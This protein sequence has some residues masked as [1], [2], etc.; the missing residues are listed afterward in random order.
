[1]RIPCAGAL[2]A[3][4]LHLISPGTAMAQRPA[5]SG[6]LSAPPVLRHSPLFGLG[7][8]TIYRGGWGIEIEGEWERAQG[9]VE[10]QRALHAD[11][12]YGVTEDLNVTLTLPLVQ[13]TQ[14]GVLSPG[15]AQVDRDVTGLG[16]VLVRGKYRFWQD[17]FPSGNHQATLF[18]AVKVPTAP[19][20]TEPPLGSGSVDFLTGA[21]VSRETHRYYAWASALARINT[22]GAAAVRR[23][24]EAR[25][26][27]ALGVRPY[28]P[29]W[30]DPDL[31]FLLEFVGVTAARSVTPAGYNPNSGGTVL[32][33]APGMWLTYRNWALK[34]GINLPFH[35]RLNGM[36]PGLDLQ[37][38][39]ALE[40]HFG[41]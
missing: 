13:K 25:W 39:F 12:H 24:H 32:A 2:V 28:V 34:A 3:A 4:G 27:L 41:G 14:G 8:Q 22:T 15:L 33:L 30:T 36:Q 35:Q 9:G 11:L 23:G 16:D 38:V 18:G 7:P 40:Y 5:P 17:L 37:T 10:S 20:T 6:R 31:M 26:D 21:A 29:Q 1:M 19:T